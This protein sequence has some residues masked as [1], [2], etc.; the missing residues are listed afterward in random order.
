M[1]YTVDSTLDPRL[2]IQIPVPVFGVD[3]V[4]MKM[5]S[6]EVATENWGYESL[7]ELDRTVT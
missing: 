7:L 5:V 4:E 2:P 6:F 3:P 1:A